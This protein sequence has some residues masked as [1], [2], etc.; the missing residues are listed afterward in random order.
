MKKPYR[1]CSG[2]AALMVTLSLPLTLG[3][4]G[5]VVDLGWAYWRTEACKTAAQAAAM[6]AAM[7]AKSAGNLTCASGVACTAN[8]STYA[9][10]PA[11]PS[12][13]PSTN[14][15]SGCLYA[16]SNGFT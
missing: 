2:Q 16:Q 7:S 3:L 14:I 13:P 6:A 10:C 1:R 12:S 5:M 4:M 11:S 9:D 15:Q 8:A